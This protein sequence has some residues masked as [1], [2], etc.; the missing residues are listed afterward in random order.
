MDE[1]GGLG[2]DCVIDNGGKLFQ[3]SSPSS[4]LH[5]RKTC[6]EKLL[7]FSLAVVRQDDEVKEQGDVSSLSSKNP[8]PSKHDVICC[9]AVAGRW[10]TS[11]QD[12][13]VGVI[14]SAHLVSCTSGVP[15]WCKASQMDVSSLD[16]GLT[17]KTTVEPPVSDHPKCEDLVFALIREWTHR[18]SLPIF[19]LEDNV[20]RAIVSYDTCH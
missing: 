14:V 13:Q 12:L 6:C 11:L 15:T 9:L 5:T 1:T 19:V 10:I 17:L 7:I 4:G 3:Y 16:E 18:G 8:L 2:V 20:L